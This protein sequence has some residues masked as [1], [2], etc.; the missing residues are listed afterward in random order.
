VPFSQ[1]EIEWSQRLAS[2]ALLGMGLRPLVG[3][4]VMD[5][6]QKKGPETTPAAVRIEQVVL[7]QEPREKFLRQ[8]LR[9]MDIGNAPA[10]KDIDGQPVRVAKFAERRT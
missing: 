7:F 6:G 3:Q 8:V 2:S 1:I 9:F 10:N 4:E 5:G